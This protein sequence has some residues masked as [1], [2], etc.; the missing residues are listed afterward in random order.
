MIISNT[1]V[2]ARIYQ[3]F[4]EQFNNP[5]IWSIVNYNDIIIML[6]N[7]KNIN[8]KNYYLINTQ[9]NEFGI[10]V[11]DKFIIRYPHY[12]KDESYKT[13]TRILEGENGLDIK[14]CNIEKYIDHKYLIRSQRMN[15]KVL[16]VFVQT[17]IGDLNDFNKLMTIQNILINNNFESIIICNFEKLKQFET[18]KNI[19]I[20]NQNVLNSPTGKIAKDL[21]SI[22]NIKNNI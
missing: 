8:F 7:W 22:R 14:Y 9:N 4:G 5:F 3:Q 20:I 17:I 18:D 13:P 19:I 6:N 10:K 11:D 15:N 16:F 2:G 12:K 1:C 21:I